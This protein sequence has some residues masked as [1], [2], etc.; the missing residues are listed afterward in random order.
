MRALVS[1]HRFEEAAAVRDR[2]ETLLRVTTD[3]AAVRALRAGG[4]V[5]VE[6]SGVTHVIDD[7]LLH[8]RVLDEVPCLDPLAERRLLAR[9][10]QRAAEGG[11]VSLRGCTGTWELPVPVRDLPARLGGTAA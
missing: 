8:H 1:A 5:E 7:G 3:A 11:N 9:T 6:V 4:R 2:V 10:I